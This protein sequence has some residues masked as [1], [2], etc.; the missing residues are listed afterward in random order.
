MAAILAVMISEIWRYPVKAMVGEALAE[1]RVGE[2]GLAGDRLWAVVDQVSNLVASA[3]YPRK[4]ERLLSLSASMPNKDGHVAV[5]FPD[6]KTGST[7]SRG[8]LDELLCDFLQAPVAVTHTDEIAQRILQRTDPDV[9]ELLNGAPLHLSP[10]ATGPIGTGAPAGTLFDFAPIHII[11]RATL[12]ALEADG[13]A[14]RSRVTESTPVLGPTPRS[15][16][17]GPLPGAQGSN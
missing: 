4:W 13:G 11:A 17:A 10:V 5:S 15:P 6:G 1:I 8:E 12:R 9:E 14:S 3:K 7:A 2:R 16:A